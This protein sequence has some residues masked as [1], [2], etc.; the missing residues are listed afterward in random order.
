MISYKQRPW[1][2]MLSVAALAGCLP[3]PAQPDGGARSDGGAPEVLAPFDAA[4]C[5][6]EQRLCEGRCVDPSSNPNHCGGCGVACPAAGP[7][8]VAV[9]AAGR[10]AVACASGFA[11]CD[12]DASNGCEADTAS[13]VAHCGRCGRACAAPAGMSPM[14]AMGT[15]SACP[16]GLQACGASCVDTQTS[17]AHCGDCGTSCGALP[18]VAGRCAAPPTLS[19]AMPATI[20]G[21]RPTEVR[22]QGTGFR[23]GLTVR[24]NGERAAVQNV[25]ATEVTVRTPPLGLD[26]AMVRVE[27]LNDDGLGAISSTILS[28]RSV[29]TSFAMPSTVNTGAPVYYVAA[30]DIDNDR[31]VDLAAPRPDSGGVNILRGSGT[32]AFTSV[33]VVA[34][35]GAPHFPVVGDF[36][37]DMRPDLAIAGRDQPQYFVLLNSGVGFNSAS[38]ALPLPAAG[39][40]VG[41]VN[42]DR[43]TDLLAASNTMNGVAVLIGQGDGTFAVQGTVPTLTPAGF[44]TLG[45]VGVDARVALVSALRGGGVVV[46]RGLSSAMPEVST[47]SIGNAQGPM[48]ALADLDESGHQD[49]VVG[50]GPSGGAVYALG[51]ADGSFASSV[52][53]APSVGSLSNGISLADINTDG[54]VDIIVSGPGSR[55]AVYPNE[56][57]RFTREL[58]VS[59]PGAP[60]SV[61]LC[62]VDGDGLLDLVVPQGAAGT[63][64]VYRNT[65]AAAR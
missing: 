18:C 41:D 57:G 39:L 53:L 17:S 61:T 11:D 63:I 28:V 62:D 29:T 6:P 31:R 23:S 59:A 50:A 55:L 12:G 9:C 20:L 25:T 44:P 51:R 27:V 24:L 35:G 60:A 13:S 56:G 8:A 52:P 54:A 49:V 38:R 37:G 47:V 45:R 21:A 3:D 4:G 43:S 64:L 2:A 19:A 14:C 46:A 5:A 10:C 32:G 15:C 7:N 33:S 42:G 36:N 34:T 48:I 30:L 26:A 58:L 1:F 65:S 22:L 40:A 16:M